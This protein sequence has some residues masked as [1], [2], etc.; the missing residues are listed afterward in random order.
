MWRSLLFTLCFFGVVDQIHG[1]S[2][3]IEFETADNKFEYIHVPRT[4][5]PCIVEEGDTIQ[6]VK[7]DDFFTVNCR[8]FRGQE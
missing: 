7:T 1:N 4:M 6:F 3:L 8:P 5:I 2:V